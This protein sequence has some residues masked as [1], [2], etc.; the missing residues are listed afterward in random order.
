MDIKYIQVNYS[1]ETTKKLFPL[2]KEEKPLIVVLDSLNLDKGQI[3]KT[4][5]DKILNFLSEQ[6]SYIDKSSTY[7]FIITKK[8]TVYK[9]AP[10]GKCG[11]C[12]KFNLYSEYASKLLP[13]HCPQTDG[14]I[15]STDISPDQV[16]ISILV[17]CD[18]DVHTNVDSGVLTDYTRDSLEDILAYCM[19]VYG[20]SS[21]KIIGRNKIPKLREDYDHLGPSFFKR[22]TTSQVL[23]ISYAMAISRK[24][25]CINL[26]KDSELNL[27]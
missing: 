4:E 11:T 21:N 7:D 22:N 16:A 2:Q 8:G 1:E 24:D 6:K 15:Y 3:Y 27:D 26:V 10:D 17:E 20:V 18:N 13:K 12:L 14:S 19:S 23:T 9:T 25:P 5:D